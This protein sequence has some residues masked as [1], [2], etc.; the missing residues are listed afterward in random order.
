MRSRMGLILNEA[1]WKILVLIVLSSVA[2]IYGI[3]N[4]KYA[5]LLISAILILV[6]YIYEKK[7]LKK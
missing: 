7:R 5:D 1:R 2:L 3:Y 4:Q 6:A